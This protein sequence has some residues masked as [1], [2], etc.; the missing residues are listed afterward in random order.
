MKIAIHQRKT[1]FSEKWI[2]YCQ[3]NNLDYKIV[4]CY[5]SNIINELK[6][7]DALMWHHYHA[8][9]KDIHFAKELIYSLEMA[10]KIVFPNFRTTWHFDDK[11]G[12]KYLLEAF[13]CPA[14]PAYGFYS[15]QD[16]L[17]WA[18]ETSFPKVFK[19]RGG[20]GADHVRLVPDY[21]K[22]VSLIN[23]AFGKGFKQYN[24]FSN[25]KERWRK[26]KA[27]KTKFADV[28]VGV[29]RLFITTPYSRIHGRD[30]GYIYFQDFIPNNTHDIRVT[31]IYGKCFA[32]RRLVRPGDF[33]ASG[34]GLSDW[35][36]KKVPEQALKT[37]FDLAK[38]LKLQSV[39]LDFVMNGNTP[40]IVEMS[41]GFGYHP[42]MFKFGYWDEELNYY[43]GEFN[44][45]GWMVEGV[46]NSV[47]ANKVNSSLY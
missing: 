36:I 4:D 22:C 28:M 12:Q 38:R 8:S 31:C 11:L 34:S 5:D 21:K 2:K 17:K 42:D 29:G 1:S 37:A 45:Q 13:D 35:D 25:L 27:G 15:K 41:Y 46:I 6:D 24:G 20:A 23:Q 44:P 40:L 43:P 30:K 26:F 3:D 47:H 19:L 16:A 33:R 39:A 14:V 9:T 18:R 10:G 32:S 7:C